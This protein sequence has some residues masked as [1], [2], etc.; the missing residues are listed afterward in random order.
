MRQYML[1]FT[2]ILFFVSPTLG[3][4]EDIVLT[5]GVP[6][7]VADSA[8]RSNL[9]SDFE[10]SH[11]GV[12]VEF[13]N[14]ENTGFYVPSE[15]DIEEHLNGVANY[16]SQADIVRVDNYS[17]SVEGTRAGYFLNMAPLVSADAGVDVMDFYPSVWQAYQWDGGIW[18]VP[19]SA[20]VSILIYDPTAF[21]AAGLAYPTP[22]WTF[23]D[24]A[25]AAR[26]LTV[27]DANGTVTMPG[28]YTWDTRLLLCLSAPYG[29]F[30]ETTL[31]AQPRLDDPQI[32]SALQQYLDLQAD[33]DIGQVAQFN[34]DSV[35]MSINRIYPIAFPS[36]VDNRELK[37]TLLPGGRAGLSVEG[38]AISAGTRHPELAYELLMYLSRNEEFAT[39]FY[40]D[41]P[42][43]RSLVDVLAESGL[44]P[45]LP[46]EVNTL[47]DAALENGLSPSELRFAGYIESQ[48]VGETETIDVDSVLQGAQEKAQQALQLADDRRNSGTPIIVITPEPPPVLAEGEVAIRFRVASNISPLPNREAW[49]NAID[50]FVASDPQVGHIIFDSGFSTIQQTLEEEYDCFY[51]FN[52]EIPV[53]DP[54][55]LLSLDPYLDADASLDRADFVNGVLAQVQRDGRTLAFPIVLSPSVLWYDSAVFAENGI[56][57]PENGWTIDQFADALQRLSQNLPDDVKPFGGNTFSPSYLLMLI[58]AYGGLPIDVS[59]QPIT[60]NF[61]SAENVEGIRQVLEL[62]KAGLLD[63]QPLAQ[64]GG[65]FG[66]TQSSPIYADTFTPYSYGLSRLSAIDASGNPVESSIRATLYPRGS[67]YTPISYTLGIAAISAKTLVSDA[68]Y[69][70]ISAISQDPALYTGVP[71]RRSAFSHPSLGSVL[72][73]DNLTFLNQVDLALNDPNTVIIFDVN[74]GATVSPGDYLIFLWLNRAF[75]RYVLEDADLEAELAAAQSSAVAYQECV[76]PIPPFDISQYPTPSDQQRYFEQFTDCL[77]LVDPE[78]ANSLGISSSD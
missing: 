74:V 8:K 15:F 38:F 1:F 19:I 77:L 36:P 55:L 42:A 23:G 48:L 28:F 65:G 51:S 50:E 69:R 16:V 78:L 10:R 76:A 3:Q 41:R 61:T 31:P 12:R 57:A 7:W 6:E 49:E 34:L 54:A 32:A 59:T 43:R 72:G 52:N 53:I 13:V 33:L 21:D 63:Y 60:L 35:P 75:D 11:S 2:L 58:A 39:L 14:T 25:M 46:P 4:E 62:A 29:F 47:I 27:R 18:A 44:R 20:S 56:P 73:E 22:D 17:L 45:N 9:L 67:R 71:A 40:G 64:F 5:V 30:D 70:W 37:G 68:C 26:Q 66:G 24:L